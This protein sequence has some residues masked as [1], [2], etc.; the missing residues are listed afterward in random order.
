[1]AQDNGPAVAQEPAPQQ[2]Q[3]LLPHQPHTHISPTIID[4]LKKLSLSAKLQQNQKIKAENR[5]WI[6]FTTPKLILTLL[7]IWWHLSLNFFFP[8]F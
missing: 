7:V 1:M 4:M 6:M 8:F 3:E 2:P 5:L